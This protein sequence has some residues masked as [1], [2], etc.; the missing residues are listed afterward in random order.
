MITIG[1]LASYAGVTIKAVR[2]YHRIGL[3]PEP[4]R[5]RSGYRTY[6]AAA[7][8]TLIRIHA[9]A[10]AGVPLARVQQLLD[11]EPDEFAAEVRRIDAQ[12]R[13]EVRRLQRNRT[14]IA[15]LAAGDSLALPPSVVDYLDRLRRIGVDERILQLERDAW[16]MVA[17]Q[18]PDEIDAVI[19]RKHAELDDPD[20]VR[21][22]LLLSQAVDWTAEEPRIVELADALE[23]LMNRSIAAG[24]SENPDDLDD[25]L[26]DLVDAT[27][28]A[29]SPVAGRLLDILHERGWRG[30]TRVQRL[31]D[32]PDET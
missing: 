2:H 22:Y 8:V 27:T 7:V 17:A 4:P 31:H 15:A 25:T 28:L 30:W 1:Q 32:L 16:I 29:S 24:R 23:T 5:D 10:D 11:A 18:V 14:R 26:I 9:L 3:L 13:A 21:L 20:M 12:L 6:D 19:G